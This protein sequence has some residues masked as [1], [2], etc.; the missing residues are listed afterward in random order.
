MY[1][2]EVRIQQESALRS[3]SRFSVTGS[4]L[5]VLDLGRAKAASR[6]ARPLPDPPVPPI[7]LEAGLP[8]V[9]HYPIED[10]AVVGEV[11]NY[12]TEVGDLEG[13]SMSEGAS[14][15]SQVPVYQL[16]PKCKLQSFLRRTSGF[17][18]SQDGEG[19]AVSNQRARISETDALYGA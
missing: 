11:V 7:N 18:V 5:A 15:S 12:L 4:N 13:F 17:P 8:N 9:S 3:S 1:K 2:A 6:A 16:T 10:S 19:G 14:A